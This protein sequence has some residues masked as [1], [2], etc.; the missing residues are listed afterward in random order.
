MHEQ[1]AKGKT[2][3]RCGAFQEMVGG[4]R[5]P[6]ASRLMNQNCGIQHQMGLP[7]VHQPEI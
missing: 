5:K 1:S 6:A 2:T 3:K 4:G 7:L